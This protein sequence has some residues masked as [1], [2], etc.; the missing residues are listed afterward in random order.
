VGWDNYR[1]GLSGS[2]LSVEIGYSARNEPMVADAMLIGF[3]SSHPDF[4]HYK[5]LRLTR[6]LPKIDGAGSVA[7]LESTISL[8]KYP[9]WGYHRSTDRGFVTTAGT[10]LYV[11]T[12]EVAANSPSALRRD[13]P[14]AQATFATILNSFRLTPAER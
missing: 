9:Q 14:K 6:Q 11:V 4:H 5:R 7:E 13:W 10:G 12:V 8:T 3:E 1:K 2:L